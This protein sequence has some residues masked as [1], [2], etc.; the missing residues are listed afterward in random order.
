MIWFVRAMVVCLFV[1]D[2]AAMLPPYL[3]PTIPKLIVGLL[4][5]LLV[6]LLSLFVGFLG[7]IVST[8]APVGARR[9]GTTLFWIGTV[10][11][12]GNIAFAVYMAID[13]AP[14]SI[15]IVVALAHLQHPS[16]LSR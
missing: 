5:G 10:V 1:V 13:G 16:L 11:A 12:I 8:K 14:V 3:T 9:A 2:A 6:V 4:T 7:S 15:A